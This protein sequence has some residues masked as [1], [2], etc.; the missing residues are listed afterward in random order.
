MK[1]VCQSRWRT[2][3]IAQVAP[4]KT[5]TIIAADPR[6][7]RNLVLHSAP[8]ERRSR[9]SRF[10]NDRWPGADF[11]K[12]KAMAA[13]VDQSTRGRESALIR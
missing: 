9:N 3:L 10:E 8:V 7:S 11:V 5:G 1:L 12:M 2:W 4:A 6:K 13:N